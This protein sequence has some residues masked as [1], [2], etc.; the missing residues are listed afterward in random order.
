MKNIGI[1]GPGNIARR[2]AEGVLSS[3][4]AKLYGVASRSLARAQEFAGRYGIENYYGSYLEMLEN[5]EVE[6]VYICTPNAFHYEQIKMCLSQGKHVICEKP[7]VKNEKQVRELF[8]LAAKNGCFL[9]EAEKTM[10]TPL[11]RKIKEMIA[12]GCIGKLLSISARYCSEGTKGLK[13]EHWVL[14]KEMG[15]CT[16]DIG[17]YPIC[18]SHFY[19]ES[20]IRE[21]QVEAVRNHKYGCDFGMEADIFYENGIYGSVRSNWFYQAKDKG[22]AILAGEKGYFEVPAYWKGDKAFLHKDGAIREIQVEMESDFEGEI[23]HAIECIEAGLLESPVLGEKMSVDIIRIV[24]AV[25]IEKEEVN[26]CF[27]ER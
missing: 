10:F 26:K 24:E 12:E 1:L 27:K 16:Y 20:R 22:K 15:G 25:Q 17:V 7:M 3:K 21:F 23:T 8:A 14:Q 13:K 4:K 18:I 9:M 2:V 5:P 6:L 11:N 19:A